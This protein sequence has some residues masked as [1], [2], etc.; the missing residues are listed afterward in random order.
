MYCNLVFQLYAGD[1][2]LMATEMDYKKALDLL[3]YIDQVCVCSGSVQV[4][5]CGVQV[6]RFV[7]VC[8][9][10]VQMCVSVWS[11]SVQVCFCVCV[12]WECTSVFLCLCVYGMGVYKYVFVSVCEWECTN[13]F[14]IV[15]VEWE[16]T[17]VYVLEVRWAMHT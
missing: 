7:S 10:S 6:Y 13:V 4:C 9:G 12:E 1:E 8:N 14:V 15:C 3:L 5:L 11:G 17:S 16:C 2:N